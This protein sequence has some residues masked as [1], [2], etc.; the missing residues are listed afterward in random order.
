MGSQDQN[1]KILLADDDPTFL[2]AV[3]EALALKYEV[4]TAEDGEQASEIIDEQGES[5]D[6]LITDIQMPKLNGLDLVMHVN[7]YHPAIKK[8]V[9]TGHGDEKIKEIANQHG[10]IVYSEK[11]VSI[12]KLF[13]YI[14]KALKTKNAAAFTGEAQAMDLSDIIQM[15]CI[16]KLT[17]SLTVTRE[18]KGSDE[19]GVIYFE[20]GIISHSIYSTSG[21][22]IEGKDAFCYIMTWDHGN[23]N[24]EYGVTSDKNT[25]DESCEQLLL[26]AFRKKDEGELDFGG[27]SDTDSQQNKVKDILIEFSEEIPE[28]ESLALI[29]SHGT[30]LSAVNMNKDNK[31]P[32]ENLLGGFVSVIKT[33][34]ENL[35]RGDFISTIIKGKQGC[36]LSYPINQE[37]ALILNTQSAINIALLNLYLEET[38]NKIIEIY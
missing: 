30:T 21:K 27:K 23:F 1:I 37:L 16:G 14:Q 32:L 35:D 38:K 8:I 13:D 20:D 5:I 24:T 19:K 34:C 25:I 4:I 18:V 22:T 15:Y 29:D 2:S 31:Q 17:A 10:T 33:A 3:N 11:P 26:E 7:Q 28:I 12:N 36:I 9:L 6:I